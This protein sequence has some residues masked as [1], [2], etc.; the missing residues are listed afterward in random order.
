M[1]IPMAPP[2]R[3]TA[4]RLCRPSK[5]ATCDG[6]PKIPLPRTLLMV[7]AT[8]LQRPITRTSPSGVTFCPVEVTARLYHKPGCQWHRPS[9]KAFG[10]S[11]FRGTKVMCRITKAHARGTSIR[12][13]LPM[14]WLNGKTNGHRRHARFAHSHR[15]RDRRP[16]HHSTGVELCRHGGAQFLIG[17]RADRESANCPRPDAPFLV[18]LFPGAE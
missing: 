9:S 17:D 5:L 12:S 15:T 1:M 10:P 4:H 13:A 2:A 3:G 6:R 14:R 16:A 7:R 11:D 18:V 8:R